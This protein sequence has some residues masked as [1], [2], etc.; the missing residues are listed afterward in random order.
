MDHTT[1]IYLMD[2]DGAYA[3]HFATNTP[4]GKMAE[5]IEEWARR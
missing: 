3:T 5:A 2:R 1:F 4:P